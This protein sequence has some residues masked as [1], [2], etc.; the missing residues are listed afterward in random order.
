MIGAG[1]EHAVGPDVF[2]P[3]R[4]IHAEVNPAL[5]R[6]ALDANLKYDLG[7]RQARSGSPEAPKAR[8]AESCRNV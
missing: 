8:R 6:A 3:C 5:D 4:A 2:P 7:I 1:A